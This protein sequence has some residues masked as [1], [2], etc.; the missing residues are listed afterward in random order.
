[1]EQKRIVI[2][3]GGYAGMM[4]QIGIRT[5]SDAGEFIQG[6]SAG[7]PIFPATLD[8]PYS[9]GRWALIALHVGLIATG[10]V[11]VIAALGV[12]RAVRLHR[13]DRGGRGGDPAAR[14]PRSGARHAADG[15]YARDPMT[16]D[17]LR[18]PSWRAPQRLSPLAREH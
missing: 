13:G 9:A 4:A 11:L 15:G 7:A 6:T 17:S 18:R 10:L 3:G 8:D 14:V 1:M 16:S 2:L 5:Q 12:L